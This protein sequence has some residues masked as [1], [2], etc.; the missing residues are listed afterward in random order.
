[1]GRDV[2]VVGSANVDLVVAVPALPA[3][4]ETV[5]G[6]DLVRHPG[7]KG[8]N[9][10]VAAARWGA[11]VG[12][13]AVLGDDAEGDAL[14]AALAADGIGLQDVHR[15]PGTPTGTALIAVAPDGA[16]LIVVS[17]GANAHLTAERVGAAADEIRGAAVTLVQFEVPDG[18]VSAACRLGRF[19][20][21]NPAPVRSPCP[22]LAD[23][24]VLVPNAG[25]LG[26]LVGARTPGSV[27]EAVVAARR[28]AHGPAVVVTLGAAGA[29]LVTADRHRHVAAP[30]VEAVDTTAAGDTFCGVL[31][32][33]VAAGADL[34]QAVAEA[35]AA[36]AVSVTRRGAQPSIPHRRDVREP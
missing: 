17:P 28:L 20:V 4:G 36:A 27:E 12:F 14:L 7:G 32:A 34:D 24:D 5:L 8:A 26:R 22:S 33:S 11:D 25:E 10:A 2:V 29:V 18:A 31:A 15:V 9:Q 6:G 35:V 1:M 19:V 30:E 13:V 16:N 23:V 21:C 3:P